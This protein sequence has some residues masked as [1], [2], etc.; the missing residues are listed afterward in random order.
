VTDEKKP[1][2]IL[3][4]E[5][6]KDYY[7]LVKTALQSVGLPD[8]LFWVENGEECMDYLLH[9]GRFQD[10]A[11]P[12]PSL[13]LLDLNMPKKNGYQTL[14]EIKSNPDLKDLP[15]IVL[16]VSRAAE[17]VARCYDLGANSFIRKPLAF[18]DLVEFLKTVYHYWFDVVQ[19]PQSAAR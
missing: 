9:R 18:P 13:L 6:D 11:A 4:A 8:Q 16:T 14:Q 15:V 7:E 1:L 3:M 12:R 10:G 5:D 17:D 2:V 19:L